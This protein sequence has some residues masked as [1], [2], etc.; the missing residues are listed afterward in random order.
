MPH[1][2]AFIVRTKGFEDERIV[3]K[4]HEDTSAI[5]NK[6]LLVLTDQQNMNILFNNA[7]LI[8][9]HKERK[10]KDTFIFMDGV[11]LVACVKTNHTGKSQLYYYSAKP[12]WLFLLQRKL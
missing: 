6:Q 12:S 4:E 7:V 8:A 1:H 2:V 3:A 9:M 5:V 11:T 10:F